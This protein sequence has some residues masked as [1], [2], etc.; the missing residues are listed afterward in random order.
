VSAGDSSLGSW[1]DGVAASTIPVD[2]RGL[3]Y[4]DGLFETILVRNGTARFLAAHLARLARG[5]ARLGIPYDDDGV[6]A[7]V[8]TALAPAPPLAIV[9]LIVTRGSAAR[10]GYAPQAGAARRIVTLWPTTDTRSMVAGVTLGVARTRAAT[11]PA[12][13]GLKHLN[14]LDNVLAAAELADGH[15]DLLMLDAADRL[16]SGTSCNLFVAHDGRLATPKLDSAG[17]A[18]VLR[19]IV[20]REAPKLGVVVQERTLT[21][22]DLAAAD[23]VL[24]TNARIGVVPVARVGQHSFR[25]FGLALRLRGHIEALDA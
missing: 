4:G 1:I 25:T 22:A 13:A 11:N 12:L 3:L 18:G 21:L 19:G 20:L 7:D 24:V 15:L 14:R 5:C 9:K 6:R 17:V 23:E 2:D 10:R 8:T 16:V